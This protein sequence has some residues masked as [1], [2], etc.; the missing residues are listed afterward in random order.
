MS[1]SKHDDE[2]TTHIDEAQKKQKK[3]ESLEKKR[4]KQRAWYQ[5]VK[6]EHPEKY[7]QIRE[8]QNVVSKNWYESKLK[9]DIEKMAA[10]AER[11]RIYRAAFK[12]NKKESIQ[13][14]ESVSE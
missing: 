9:C 6:E 13:R 7:Q 2:M 1:V 8:K 10:N 5:R 4:A 12:L 14:T 11:M 3:I